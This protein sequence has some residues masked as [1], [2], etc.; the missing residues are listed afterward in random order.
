MANQR[1]MTETVSPEDR[2][3]ASVA[4]GADLSEG[5]RV[6]GRFDVEVLSPQE[7]LRAEYAAM[8][9]RL[10]ELLAVP[11]KLSDLPEILRLRR[12]IG[13][14]PLS[15]VDRDWIANLVTTVGRNNMW[16]NH[17]A[18][19]TYTAAWYLGL[20]GSASYTTGPAAGDDMT[21]HGGWAEDVTYSNGT[22]PSTSW[23]AASGG[24]KALSAASQFTINGSVTEKGCFLCSDST[25]SGTSGVL[26]SAGTFSGGDKVLQSSDTL[27]VSYTAQSS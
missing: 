4:R 9:A 27:S 17:L 22:R 3:S 8:R 24:N 25:K 12:E 5:L 11:M 20:I 2:V 1:G 14:V 23:A 16:D 21:T 19:S 18:G 6:S 10:Y 7:H 26:H 13:A 15:V